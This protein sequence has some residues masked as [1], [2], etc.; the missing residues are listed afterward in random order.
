[1]DRTLPPD[2]NTVAV[3]DRDHATALRKHNGTWYWLDSSTENPTP[4]PSNSAIWERV[5]GSLLVLCGLSIKHMGEYLDK[6][7]NLR[8]N[9][10]V[11]KAQS[12]W[13]CRK[14]YIPNAGT[15]LLKGMR[16]Q[17]LPPTITGVRRPR[18]H[19]EAQDSEV[20]AGNVNTTTHTGITY[21]LHTEQTHRPSPGPPHD[22]RTTQTLK[23]AEW[24]ITTWNVNDLQNT[25]AELNYITQDLDPESQTYY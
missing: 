8:Y 21:P 12:Y 22:K 23:Q 17:P 9:Y 3:L 10:A 16:A 7:G 13:Q 24:R 1:M 25:K 15:T 18:E 6:S 4:L 20:E 19:T 14:Y 11:S 2:C 5:K